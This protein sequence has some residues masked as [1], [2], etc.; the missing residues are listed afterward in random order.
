MIRKTSIVILIIFVLSFSVAY[1]DG[2]FYKSATEYDYPPFSV[3]DEGVADGFSVDLLK[4][5]AAEVGINI[6]FKIDDWAII[7]QELADGE[8]DVLPL[9]GY[10]EERDEV[11]DFT[12]PYIIMHG[13]IFIRKGS[14]ISTEDDLYGK[15]IVVMRGDNAQEYAELMNFTDTLI[16]T[17]TYA[18]AF[19]LLASGQYDAVLAQNLVGQLIIDD[20]GLDNLEPATSI[21]EENQTVLRTNLKG[22]EHKLCFAVKE[23]DKELLAKL[24]E[25]LA[26]VSANGT[27]DELY[28]KWFP[29][30]L[31]TTPTIWEALQSMLVVI[32]PVVIVLLVFAVLYTRRQV[33]IKK[34]ELEA[35]NDAILSM[36][37]HLINKQK[38]ES[39]GVLA[40]GVAHEINNP[41]N[42][43]MNYGQIINDLA[44]SQDGNLN[45]SR[46]NIEI[47]SKEIIQ[48]TKRV[49]TIVSNL[50]TFSRTDKSLSSKTD[51]ETL[52]EGVL[53]LCSVLI[54]RNSIS[55]EL[56]IEKDLPQVKCRSQQIQQVLLNLLTNAKDALII[57][58]PIDDYNKKI[59]I[60]AHQHVAAEKK[61]VRIT[62]EDNGSGIPIEAQ[63]HIFEPF[64][65]TK[66]RSD[67]TGLGLAISYSIM[68]DHGGFLSFETEEGQYT[69]FHI[70]LPLP[71]DE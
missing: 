25:G 54:K 7:K 71:Q 4:A 1:A 36:E 40:S 59:L 46:E 2:E 68:K 28:K 20:L 22:F 65:T 63:K 32:I 58:Y 29:F 39:I 30:L 19:E 8:L 53:S 66:N 48:E 14:P 67:G 55:I 64:F 43:I 9:V 42:G 35:S 61:V 11:Y 51:A 60:S 12:A 24:N 6:S 26:I 47:Y 18:E 56:D 44:A 62:V 49:S 5:V 16:L 23:G 33:N 45:E 41:I 38:L 52:I 17:D 31:D 21:N 37:A 10:T 69:K 27:Y 57:K 15:Q 50:L 3:T 70:D 34:R 13:N